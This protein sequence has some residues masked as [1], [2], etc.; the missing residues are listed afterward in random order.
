MIHFDDA[1]LTDY[2]VAFPILQKYGITATDYVPTSLVGTAG[3]MTVAQLVELQNN[4]WVIGNHTADHIML[5]EL[6]SAGQER[7]IVGGMQT[8]ESWGLKGGKHLSYPLGKYNTDTLE[9]LKRWNFLSGRTVSNAPDVYPRVVPYILR[10][11]QDVTGMSLNDVLK[12][13][14]EAQRNRRVLT[15]LFHELDDGQGSGDS[16]NAA[17]FERLIANLAERKIQ[18]LTIDEYM[19]LAAGGVKVK[20]PGGT[21]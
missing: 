20:A 15:L 3:H 18:T 13:V 14:D 4:G 1:N 16:W 17:D 10:S 9:I 11:T 2:T 8:L 5:R 19:R 6:D 12:L 21:K 7:E